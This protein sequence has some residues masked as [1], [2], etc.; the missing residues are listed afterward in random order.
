MSDKN[1]AIEFTA[2]KKVFPIILDWE[3][4]PITSK[5][6]WTALAKPVSMTA[7]HA[8]FAGPEIM[9][10][11]PEE[12]HSFD[13]TTIPNENQTCFPG[14]GDCLWYYQGKY[15]MKG[16]P[17][18]LWEIGIF[19][20][21]GGRTFGPLGWTPVNIFGKIGGDLDDFAATCRTIRVDGAKEVLLRQG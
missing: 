9:M 1:L 8:M 15:Q 11:L 4:T 3:A 20:D 18:E 5:T 21:D 14:P 7:F 12:A 2:H 13:P 19:Y 6:L 17:D 16:L 10:G